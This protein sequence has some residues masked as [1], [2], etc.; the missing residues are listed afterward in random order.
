MRKIINKH[1]LLTFFSFFCLLSCT[2]EELLFEEKEVNTQ[3]VNLNTFEGD[4]FKIKSDGN[5]LIFKSV[6]DYA[7]VVTNPTDEMR[8]E[9]IGKVSNMNHITYAKKNKNSKN[10]SLIKDDYFSQ[11]LN[12][13]NAVQIGNYIYKVNKENETVF[14]LPT[15][16][17]DQYSDLI[18]EN[19]NNIN[20]QQ[21]ST[22]DDV[23]SLVES[24]T[25]SLFER[26][27]EDA[28]GA[29][30]QAKGFLTPGNRLFTMYANYEKF[31]IYCSASLI[32]TSSATFGQYNRIYIQ[33]ENIWHKA[34]CRG[35]VGPYSQPWWSGGS[36][37]GYSKGFQ[38]YSGTR[39]LNGYH[40]KARARYEE[41]TT[42]NYT[43]YFTNWS[44][45]EANS[46]Y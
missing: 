46:P 14:V 1:I 45:I 24:G 40:L 43:T 2:E 13:D 35:A 7:K 42:S 10:K 28:A 34:K 39:R 30:N 5:I 26:C 11:I 16:F 38:V 36:Q 29:R 4:Y 41:G 31:G 25:S 17:K 27:K 15:E 23:I 19:L 37:N 32:V 33:M 21:Y 22:D 3:I 12:K 6:D 8:N 9:F 20:I 44:E 18:N